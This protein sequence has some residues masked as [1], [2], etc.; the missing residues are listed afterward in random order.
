MR[1]C[2][3]YS[4]EMVLKVEKQNFGKHICYSS[5]TLSTF[6]GR[7]IVP[8][9]CRCYEPSGCL[10]YTKLFWKF[11]FIRQKDLPKTYQSN[12]VASNLDNI[13][14]LIALFP[15][16]DKS[17]AEESSHTAASKGKVKFYILPYIKVYRK[18]SVRFCYHNKVHVQISETSWN[19][20]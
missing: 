8:T 16:A 6:R 1:P 3:W 18:N 4:S 13:F 5:K 7:M 15:L 19:M 2:G 10:S 14:L 20:L 9:T 17:I 12:K 11:D